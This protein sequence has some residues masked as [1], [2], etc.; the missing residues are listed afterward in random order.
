MTL[1]THSIIAAAVTRPI[2][3]IHPLLTLVVAVA[4]HYLSDSIP[5]W[6]YRITSIENI[7][8]K[9]SRHL[10]TN[11]KAII[12]DIRNFAID[13]FLGLAIVTAIT[14][15]M[16]TEQW[17]WVLASVV[18]GCLPDFLQGLYV[19]KLKFLKLLQRFHDLFHTNI[20]LG[21]YAPI[22]VP[23]Q[24]IIALAAIYTLM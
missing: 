8:D 15:P 21:P 2:S 7:E 10:G 6:D 1:A 18:G 22:G 3:H 24:L 9:D 11:R 12:H 4:T 20:R 17:L 13:G 19:L 16:T 5:H 23:F 14:R